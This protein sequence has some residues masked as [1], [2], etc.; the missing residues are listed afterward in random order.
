MYAIVDCKNFYASCERVFQPKLLRTPIVVLSNNDGCV[1]ARS[2]EAKAL[3]IKMGAP[4]FEI[5][6]MMAQHGV[7]AFSS[8]YTLYGDMS[9][10]VMT[11]LQ[12][13]ATNMEIYSIDEAFLSLHR[14]PYHDL[15]AYAMDIRNTVKQYTGIPVGIGVAATKTLAKAANKYAKKVHGDK[16]VFVIDTEE[17]RVQVLKWLPLEDVWG[18][19]RRFCEKLSYYGVKTAYDLSLLDTDFIRYGDKK[20]TLP[21]GKPFFQGMGVVGVRLVNELNGTSCLRLEEIAPAKQNIC[22]SRSFARDLTNIEDIRQAIATHTARCAEKLRQQ[23]SCAGIIMVFLMTNQFKDVP[24]YGRNIPIQ[25]TVPTSD[26]RELLKYTMFALEKI[27]RKGYGYKKAGVIVGEIVPETQ[28]QASLFDTR[29]RGRNGA[30]MQA[31]DAINRSMGQDT[32]RLATAGYG[33]QWRLRAERKSPC[34]TTNIHEI[35]KIKL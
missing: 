10:R 8:N 31:M 28:V 4:A 19:G 18:I 22:T 13:F 7:V 24:Q 5:E 14:M 16:G 30:L 29:N 33:R 1:I 6:Q 3:G 26:T 11:V 35:L 21:N 15:D 12:Q 25:L 9:N 17:K 32:V 27:F 34:Y 20:Y 2:D 23:N